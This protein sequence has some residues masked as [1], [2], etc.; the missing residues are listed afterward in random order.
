MH[1]AREHTFIATVHI[2]AAEAATAAAIRLKAF[3][4]KKGQG[5]LSLA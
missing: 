1:K 4:E 5:K 2:A 3:Q